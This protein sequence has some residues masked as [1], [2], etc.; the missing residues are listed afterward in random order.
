ML[1]CVEC[2]LAFDGVR[3][4][5][6][7]RVSSA[8]HCRRDVPDAMRDTGLACLTALLKVLGDFLFLFLSSKCFL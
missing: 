7:V 2:R 1:R 6:A 3:E 5:R 8:A 4:W